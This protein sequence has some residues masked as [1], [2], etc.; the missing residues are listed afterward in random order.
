M[1]GNNDYLTQNEK[2][3]IIKM[4]LDGFNTVQIAKELG[5][6][7]S[8]IG[9]YLR[10]QGYKNNKTG[11]KLSD[12]DIKKIKE[13]YKGGMTSKE[14]FKLFTNKIKCE[15]TIQVIIRNAGLSRAKGYRNEFNHNYFEE[16]NTASKAYFLGL[17]LTDGN[18]HEPKR[19]NRQKIIQIG[20]MIKDKYILEELKLELNSDNK[21]I[22]YNNN[23][24]SE[25][26]FRVSSNKMANDLSQYGITPQKTFLIDKAPNISNEFLPDLIRG[27][28]DGDGTVYILKSNNKLRFG[29][30][31]T[32]K[33]IEDVV[34]KLNNEINIPINKI[35]DKAT[36]SFIT[37]GAK[38]DIVNFYNY[39]YYSKD[40]VCLLRKRNKFEQI[41]F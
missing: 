14:I 30:Y 41:L 19:Q 31:G 24:R 18:V 1:Y 27:I 23:N 38:K 3:I 8:S 40:V 12:N 22:E 39:I 29:F 17:L 9:R 36:V 6:N 25:C 33:L 35:T 28:F 10:K 21:I 34:N 11:R 2:E 13:L 5:R 32:H 37:F 26:Y 20:L 15:E 16:I 4:H 7:N